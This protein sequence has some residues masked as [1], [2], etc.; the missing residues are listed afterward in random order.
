MRREPGWRLSPNKT[1]MRIPVIARY[2]LGA[3]GLLAVLVFAGG[4]VLLDSM[5]SNQFLSAA[6]SPDGNFEA[7]VFQR[8]C[9]GTTGFSTQVSI[10]RS[11]FPRG[12]S[13][14]NVFVADTNHGA[15]P[16][17]VG[18]G[19]EIKLKWLSNDTLVITHPA[20][21]RTFLTETQWNAVKVRY[22]EAAF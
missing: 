19:P 12:N 4:Y 14:G 13:S 1:D 7:V 17:G 6:K 5:C 22:E 9:G 11:G 20:K 21:V 15:A 16:A 10:F 2:I 18:G 8:D 3:V